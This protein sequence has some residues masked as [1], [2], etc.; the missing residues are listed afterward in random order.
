MKLSSPASNRSYKSMKNS[1]LL[2][3]FLAMAPNAFAAP[4]NVLFIAVDDLRPE[5]KCYGAEYAQTPSIDRLAGQSIVFRNHFVQVATCGASRYALLTGRSPF[6]SGVTRSNQSFYRG[7]SAISQ[8]QLAAAQSMPELF[9]RSGY[10]TVCIGKISHTADGRVYEYNGSGNGRDEVPH[11]WDELAT[12]FGS[13]GRGWGIFFA[14]ANGHH[15]EDGAGHKDLVEFTAGQD[16]ELPDGLLA[17][18][19]IEKLAEFKNSGTPF[20]LGLGFI[21]PHLPFVA[22]R[23]DWEAFENVKIPLP[24]YPKK[25]S[26]RFWHRSGEFFKYNFPFDKTPPLSP[27]H[28]RY[29]R[30]AY[31]ACVRYTDRQVGKVLDSLES[32]GLADN[33][34]VVLWGDHGWNLGDSQM[35]AKHAPFER[36]VRSPLMIRVPGRTSGQFS[37]ALVETLDIYPTLRALCQPGFSA[38][39]FPLDGKNLEPLIANPAASIRQAAFSFWGGAVSIRTKTHRLVAVKE[40]KAWKGLE[41][42]DRQTGFDPVRNLADMHPEIVKEMLQLLPGDGE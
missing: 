13:W 22:P 26:S 27:E 25:I 1:L 19:A 6:R 10:R 9:R 20:F 32:T 35:W 42:Y 23:Q 14:Y 8:E 2:L 30:R 18:A 7:N 41:L 21:K 37:D 39:Q 15:R 28:V 24:P 38:T 17:A 5:L 40:E 34:I 16:T 29:C 12:P 4:A 33:T 3:L 11:A 31:L 36:A